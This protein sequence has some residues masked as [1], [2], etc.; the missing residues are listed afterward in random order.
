MENKNDIIQASKNTII[1]DPD[2]RA[3]V[4]ELS[5]RYH[6][7]QIRAAIGINSEQLQF[8]WSLGR[9]IISMHVEE[10][11]G[12]QATLCR[13]HAHPRPQR[14]FRYFPRLHEAF[15]SALSR[16]SNQFSPT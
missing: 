4:N 16:G 8:Y 15:L 13:P 3:W 5:Q 6:Q 1:A 2:Y 14:F 10:R 9:D 12:H 7:S 11:W